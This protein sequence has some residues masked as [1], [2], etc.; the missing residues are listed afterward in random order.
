MSVDY[1]SLEIGI[2]RACLDIM[3]RDRAGVLS[4]RKAFEWIKNMID[5]DTVYDI[6]EEMV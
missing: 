5:W 6:M 4:D 2:A 3:T 1:S